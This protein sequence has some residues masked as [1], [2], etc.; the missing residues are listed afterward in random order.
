M[1]KIAVASSKISAERR[2]VWVRN[3]AVNSWGAGEGTRTPKAI[4]EEV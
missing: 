3:L 2:P 4:L 1:S